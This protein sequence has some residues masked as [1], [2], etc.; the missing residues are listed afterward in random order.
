MEAKADHSEIAEYALKVAESLAPEYAEAYVESSYSKSFALEQGIANGSA[1]AEETGIRIRLIKK[2]ALYTFSTNKLDKDS[3]RLLVKRFRPFLGIKTKLSDE[4]RGVADY[5]VGEKKKID[6]AN[7][8]GDLSE[9]DK[10]LSKLPYVK[11]RNLYG[12]IGRSTSYFLN[13]QGTKI[14]CSIPIVNAFVSIIV[15]N[16]KETRQRFMQFGGSGG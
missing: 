9:I 3:I 8:L 15:G 11:F 12:G 7:M 2:G 10:N 1:Y 13:S 14:K 6:N 4:K 5:K 16:G